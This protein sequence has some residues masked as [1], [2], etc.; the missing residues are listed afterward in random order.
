MPLRILPARAS[1]GTRALNGNACLDNRLGYV[2]QA[3]FMGQRVTGPKQIMQVVWVY[4]HP[5]DFDGVS[6]FHHN[7]G[8]GLLGRRIERSPLPF[9]R[10]RWVLDRGPKD[11]DIAQR[12]RPRAEVGDWADER[13]QIP[14]DPESGP[15]WHLGVLP[16]TDGSTAVSLVIS[17]YLLDGLGLVVSGI[18][19]LSGITH[20]FNYPP[21]RSRTRLRALVEDARQ[22]AQQAPEV[23][24][25][26]VAAAKQ[27]RNQRQ[28]TSQSQKS[29]PPTLRDTNNIADSVVVV[30]TVTVLVDLAD[31]DSCAEALGGTSKTLLVGFVAKF[32]EH[33]G[34]RR[35]GDDTVTVQLPISTRAEGDMRAN[36]VSFARVS[37]DP[38][39]V[40]TD[41]HDVRAAIKQ[42]LVTLRE[43]STEESS[44][45][46]SLIPF[47][48]KR[49]LK[50]LSA[51][52]YAMLSEA[53]PVL[54]SNLG[55]LGSVVCRLDGSDAEF[56][57]GRLAFQHLTQRWLECTGGLMTVQSW[58]LHNRI[59]IS[60]GA[61][62]PG[63]EN[64]KPA[65]RE[66]AARTMGEFNLIGEIT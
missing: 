6:R 34:R 8:R 10:Y 12:P 14:V 55:D 25:A 20:D 5:L 54:C 11:I 48:P 59:V 47:I 18:E 52:D 45:V 13:S 50:R 26:L 22:T 3:L 57:T 58:R 66:L 15:G 24:R 62:Q 51:L 27:A 42:A 1:V 41:L 36:A 53:L 32:A 16:L 31:W 19:A 2:D 23:G 65:M 60:I 56:V 9:A 38:T 61:Y 35:A 63:A 29:R 64:T 28:N 39:G 4:E 43:T 49:V 46:A 37:V 33:V 30:P 17:H 7:L 21:P 44:Q 40:T